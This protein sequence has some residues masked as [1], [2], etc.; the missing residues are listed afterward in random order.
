MAFWDGYRTNHHS[1]PPSYRENFPFSYMYPSSLPRVVH[2]HQNLQISTSQTNILTIN[3]LPWE[4]HVR[5][6]L[7]SFIASSESELLC[8]N[9]CLWKKLTSVQLITTKFI[10]MTTNLTPYPYYSL[11]HALGQSPKSIRDVVE[12]SIR[13]YEETKR[14]WRRL[15]KSYCSVR[16]SVVNM[17]LP[18]R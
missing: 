14:W 15:S 18:T 10:H 16:Y 7:L 12:K 13:R 17:W 11:C 6:S 5:I 9:K 3:S 2:L 4:V 8:G 1:I